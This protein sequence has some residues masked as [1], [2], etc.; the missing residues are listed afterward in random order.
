MDK[1][2]LI[3]RNTAEILGEDE[4]REM[5]KKGK[6]PGVYLGT[7][8][9][10]SPHVA[11]FTWGIKLADFAKAGCKVKLLLADLHGAMDNTPWDVLEKKYKYYEKIF[12]LMFE[13]LGVKKGIEYV[14][15]SSFQLSKEFEL[16]LMKLSTNVSV[17]DAHKAAS[18]VVKLGDNPK[19]GGLL[20]P[21][22]QAL[23]E[24]Y[25]K[26]D[27]Q[28]GG[29]DQRKIFVL[30]MESLPKIGYKKRIHVMTPM[31]PGL[32]GKKMSAS[33]NKSKIDFLDSRE[34]VNKKIRGADCVAGE[35][36]NGL[37]GFL[38]YV[39]FVVKGDKGEKFVIKRDK[40]YGGDL[41][42][43]NYLDLEKD[44]MAKKVHPLDLKNA[45]AFE[46]NN[47]LGP[48]RKKEK[49][50]RKLWKDAYG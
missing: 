11:Y 1:F 35:V 8:I 12:P 36:D 37:M 43:G 9:T 44:F 45:V 3:K 47:L 33:D 41:S 6:K 10:G 21:L 25:L 39:V 14:K 49:E 34:E 13:A 19:L 16:D 48:I 29:V 26:V 5:L 38:K 22:M 15:G 40:K 18:E 32:V 23:D 46:I 42:Y 27:I 24:E 20:Y 28:Y 2:E 31:I 7:A 4:L 17:H 50:L 30:A